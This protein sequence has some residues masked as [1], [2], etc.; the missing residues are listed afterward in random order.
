[1]R[2]CQAWEPFNLPILA[3]LSLGLSSTLQ[4]QAKSRLIESHVR[5]APLMHCAG[6]GWFLSPAILHP[7]WWITSASHTELVTCWWLA[8]QPFSTG[9]ASHP[10]DSGSTCCV[11]TG[12]LWSWMGHGAGTSPQGYTLPDWTC[13]TAA[14][15]GHLNEMWKLNI[16]L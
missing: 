16:K 12:W 2:Y 15:A 1:M 4:H 3:F 9:S 10:T 7:L 14:R 8:S 11:T 13:L 5:S 6:T